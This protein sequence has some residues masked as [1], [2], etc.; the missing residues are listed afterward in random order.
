MLRASKFSSSVSTSG[1]SH[2]DE[3]EPAEDARDLSLRLGQRVERAARTWPTRQRDVLALVPKATLE[4]GCVDGL[5]ASGERGFDGLADGIGEGADPGSVLRRERAD[6]AQ[7][8]AQLTLAPEDPGLDGVE[9]G[10]RVGSRD[11]GQRA[12]AQ[13]LECGLERGDVHDGL[14]ARRQRLLATSAMRAKVAASRT[15][16]S[17]RT[18]RSSST[19]A[20]FRPLM[21]D[22]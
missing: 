8:L 7:D 19:P 15:Q 12:G 9:R 13:S 10:R 22:P 11:G 5:P 17:A 6:A 14:G 3:A 21:S 18:L 1:L 16:I 4:V 2:D 20:D